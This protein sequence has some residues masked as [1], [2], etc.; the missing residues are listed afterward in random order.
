MGSIFE[1]LPWVS[2]LKVIKTASIPI[3]KLTINTKIPV[4]DPYFTH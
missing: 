3:I 2:K 4:N 1:K